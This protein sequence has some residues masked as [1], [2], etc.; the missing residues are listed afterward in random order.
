M[1]IV[2]GYTIADIADIPRDDSLPGLG[3][4]LDPEKFLTH[5]RIGIGDR[6]GVIE[7]CTIT[8]IR[9]KPKT[10]CLVAYELSVKE[11]C[12]EKPKR[13]IFY[14]KLYT[15]DDYFNALD[16]SQKVRWIKLHDTPSILPL[17]NQLAILYFFPN[18]CLI[19]GL[20]ILSDRKKVQRLLYD[21]LSGFPAEDWRISD[22]RLQTTTVRYKPERRAVIRVDTRAVNRHSG[23]KKNG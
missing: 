22:S 7:A 5:L 23:Q 9:Y 16:K 13:V 14:A 12:Q 19:D 20:R 8:Y 6:L 17:D 18:D 21:S 3:V 1:L 2:H 15:E 4:M 11:A 10:N